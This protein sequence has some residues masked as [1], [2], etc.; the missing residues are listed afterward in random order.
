MPNNKN[1]LQRVLDLVAR[2]GDTMV[3]VE[4]ESEKAY[5]VMDINRY[6]DLLDVNVS[7]ISAEEESTALENKTPKKDDSLDIW[8]VMPEAQSDAQT[9]DPQQL[10]GQ[11]IKELE[12]QYDQFAAKTVEETGTKKKQDEDFGEEQFYLEPVE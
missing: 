12:K 8:D 6:E 4:K 11:E 7:E 1:Q 5:V 3:V 9:W 10:S 2:T